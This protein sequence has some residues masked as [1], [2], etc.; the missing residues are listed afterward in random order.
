MQERMFLILIIIDER[1]RIW[2]IIIIRYEKRDNKR[3]MI[4]FYI[5]L[6]IN[7]KVY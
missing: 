3:W 5:I 4:L 1:I 7:E 6:M 2:I